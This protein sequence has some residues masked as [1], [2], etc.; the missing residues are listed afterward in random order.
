[1]HFGEEAWRTFERGCE[2]EWLVTN[3]LGGFA[4][5]TIIGANTRRY[6]GLLI[7][8]LKPPTRRFLLVAKID[9]H[10]NAGGVYYNLGTNHTAGGVTDSGFVH[11]QRV[12]VDPFPEFTYSFGQILLRKLIFMPYG[13]NAT[14]ILYRVYNGGPRA[15]LALIPMVNCRGY[16]ENHYKGEVDFRQEPVSRGIKITG[17]EGIPPLLLRSDKGEFLVSSDWFYGMHYPVEAERGLN[18]WED[19]FLPGRFEVELPPQE[20]TVFTVVASAGEG[21]V[22]EMATKLLAKELA[23]LGKIEKAAGSRDPLVRLLARAADSFVVRRTVTGIPTIIAGYPWFTDWGRDAMIALPGLTLITRRF[24]EAREI[25]SFFGAHIKNGLLPNF[26]P[27]DGG[28][29]LYNTVDAA[30]WYFQAVY[31]YLQYTNDEAFVLEAMLPVLTEILTHY[32]EGTRFGIRMDS[33]GLIQ[34]GDPGIQLTWMDAKVG[35]WVVTP[36]HGKAVEINALWYNAVCILEEIHKRFGLAC[37]LTGL[38]QRV[39]DGFGA[40]WCSEGYLYDVLQSGGRDASIRPNQIFAVSLPHS[41]L[42]QEQARAVV[43]KVETELY[44]P[45]GLRS[46]SPRDPAYKGCYVGN[47]ESRDAAYHQGTVWSWLIG[48]F[49]TAFRRVNNYSEESRERA[50]AMLLPFIDHLGDHGV[51]YI[52]EIF[53]GDVPH[54]PRGCIAQAWGVAE[55]L[56]AYVEDVL[57]DGKRLP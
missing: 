10:V 55:I 16:H 51:G 25:L 48:P 27:D 30:L 7:A 41:P 54:W 4:S 5:S 35:D 43:N 31:K 17:R 21:P 40:F 24:D 20:E 37:P 2:R 39:R 44:T 19:H 11:L 1:M 29:P 45:Y 8:A 53:D 47:P 23:R 22:P 18:P 42:S 52:S 9:E 12:V 49:V 56:R 32:M 26:F 15:N 46:L 34:A 50:R 6:H 33:D 57:G 28:E 36:R 3:G 38:R 14:V 13:Q